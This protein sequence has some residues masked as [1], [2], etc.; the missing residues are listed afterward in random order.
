MTK[1][2]LKV[3]SNDQRHAIYLALLK[4]SVNGRLKRGTTKA[5]AVEFTVNIRSVER[6]WKRAKETS[7]QGQVDVSHLKTKN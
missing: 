4:R 1:R 7:S 2:K 5:V 6:I 3:L